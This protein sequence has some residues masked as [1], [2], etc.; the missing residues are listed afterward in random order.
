MKLKVLCFL[1]LS[2]PTFAANWYVKK[3]ASGTNAGTSWT[4]AWPD[5]SS[6]AF[7]SVACG[8][9]IWIAG[10]NGGTA[11]ATAPSGF[12]T[13]TSGNPVLM[14][15][16]LATDSVPVAAAGWL[17]TFDSQVVITNQQITMTG[18]WW[19]I[20]GRVGDARTGVPYGILFNNSQDGWLGVFANNSSGTITGITLAYLEIHGPACLASC[21]GTNWALRLDAG[22][23]TGITVDHSWLHRFGEIIHG[24]TNASSVFVLTNSYI[25]EDVFLDSAEHEDWLYTAD[26]CGK[27]TFVGNTWYASGN[28]GIFMDFAGCNN[29]FTFVNNVMFG[30]GGWSISFGKTGSCGPYTIV[31]NTFANNS[32]GSDGAGNEYPYGFMDVGGCTVKT[33]SLFENNIAYNMSGFGGT[34]ANEL[35]NAGTFTNGFNFSCGT[36]CFQYSIASPIN[37]FTGFVNFTAAGSPYYSAIVASD[38]HLS[39]AGQ[40]LFK[41]KGANL[42][43]MCGTIPAICL[44]KDGNTRPTTGAWDLGAYQVTS[45]GIPPTGL[46]ATVN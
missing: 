33:T 6:I 31:N 26:P 15:R 25:G 29:G 18:N 28:D 17:S 10:T 45:Q 13:C 34:N 41:G 44:D 8:D 20:D 7:A 3:G 46:T 30:W 14:R 38:L 32:K 5:F 36:G 22:G 35:F 39:T 42:T 23:S 21:T 4:N 37:S 19:T 43:S 24:P 16:V 40:T 9:T 27:M 2:L 11:Y 1:L 12:K